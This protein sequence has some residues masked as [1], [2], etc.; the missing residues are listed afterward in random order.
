MC[1]STIRPRPMSDNLQ[2]NCYSEPARNGQ[3]HTYKANKRTPSMKNTSRIAALIALPL[4]L[5][6]G[7]AAQAI[8]T[9]GDG[10][11]DSLTAQMITTGYAHSCVI[12]A[13]GVPRCWGAGTTNTGSNFEFGQSIIPALVNPVAISAGNRHT[14]ALDATGVHC[15]GNNTYGQTIVP[16][17]TN[18]TAVSAGGNTSCALDATGVH[19]WGDNFYGQNTVPALTNPTAVSTGGSTACALDATGV[20]C[21]GDNTYGQT[22]VPALTNPTAVSAGGSTS[23]ALNATGVLCWGSSAY[24]KTP[25][26]VL[27]NPTAV[28]AG[29]GDHICA[30]DDTGV[31]C[32]GANF[33]GQTT[34][35]TLTN[36][37]AVSAGVIHTCAVDD[38]GVHCWG[39]NTYGQSVDQNVVTA[40]NCPAIANADQLDRDG[41]GVGNAC[42]TDDDN[43]GTPDASDGCPLDATATVDSDGDGL[44]DTTDPLPAD[45]ITL[46]NYFGSV[47]AD[48][49]GSA[50]AFAGDVNDDGYGDYVVGIPNYDVPATL[51]A[52][53]IK[54]A[55]RAEV[56]SGKDGIVLMSV[57]G[58]AAG[59]AMGFAVAGNA[60]IDGDGYDDVVLGAPKTDGAYK[61]SG[62]FTVLYGPSGSRSYTHPFGYVGELAGS[63]VALGD[64]DND[65]YADIVIGAPNAVVNRL[66]GAGRVS[67]FSGKDFSP[68]LFYFYEGAA[69]KTYAG[70]ALAVGNVD[71][72]PGLDVIIGSPNDD[73]TVNKLKDAGSV[74]VRNVN[75]VDVMKYYGTVAGA[76]LGASVANAHASHSGEAVLAGAPGDNNDLTPN[77]FYKHTGS[78]NIFSVGGLPY[79]AA[80]GLHANDALGGVNGIA[81]GDVN[82]DGYFDI[83]TGYKNDPYTAAPFK[84]VGHAG[85]VIVWYGPLFNGNF[86][87]FGVAANDYAGSSVAAGDINGDGKADVMIGIP[88]YDI[89]ATPD[90]KAIKDV[91]AVKVKSG[92]MWGY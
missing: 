63:A 59:D 64:I 26:P 40:D 50:V 39:S 79:K 92:A 77:Q 8:D 47:K 76:H 45:P 18:P 51:D 44:C 56:I 15:W 1:P 66:K 24:G 36:P 91:G 55:G 6:A 30:L 23:C 69:A 82:G 27:T 72:V 83:I 80:Y 78:V 25:G 73:D 19:C 89:P 61:D 16:T 49:V 20:H 58:A 11:R 52:K 7:A 42:D 28:S 38:E 54:N 62:S 17:L 60:D 70:S 21:W 67:V 84:K 85:G 2:M 74:T 90:A 53:I 88:G 46:S 14:C 86:Q 87:R 57:N 34:V 43:D 35:P 9:D 68:A 5:L 3:V 32:W 13:D 41:D 33:S 10:V 71:N 4:L 37:T 12:A 65:G 31:H 22:T 29:G 48:K 81:V 75:G